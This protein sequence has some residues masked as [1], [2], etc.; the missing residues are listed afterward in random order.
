MAPGV[1]ETKCAPRHQPVLHQIVHQPCAQLQLQHLAEPALRHVQHQQRAGDDAEHA[2]LVHELGKVPVRQGIVERL[3]PAIEAD[4]PVGGGG[5]DDKKRDCEEQQPLRAG[6]AHNARAIMVN[7]GTSPDSAISSFR[8]GWTTARMSGRSDHVEA[9]SG[10]ACCHYRRRRGQLAVALSMN[11]IERA[12][13]A[14]CH[15][16]RSSVS[17]P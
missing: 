12:A 5:D 15:W 4:L 11:R 7:C 9:S 3:I 14:R 1:G 17:S 13:R 6:E 10:S 16:P 2:Q 8:C